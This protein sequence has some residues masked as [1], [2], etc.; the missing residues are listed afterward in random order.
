MG[1]M[2]DDGDVETTAHCMNYGEDMFIRKKQSH[3]KPLK[4]LYRVASRLVSRHVK[5]NP[6]THHSYFICLFI[7]FGLYLDP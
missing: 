6:I 3:Y 5:P 7:S 2:K 1:K 4:P